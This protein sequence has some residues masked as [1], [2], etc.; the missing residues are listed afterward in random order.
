ME[1]TFPFPYAGI[2]EKIPYLKELGISA[3]VLMPSYEFD[4]VFRTEK[5]FS[6]PEY[7]VALCMEQPESVSMIPA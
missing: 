1:Y 5:E 4:E 6:G 7:P 3:V 2:M